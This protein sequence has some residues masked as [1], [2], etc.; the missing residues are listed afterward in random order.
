MTC[1]S[2]QDMY[3]DLSC[4]LSLCD[5]RDSGGS[6]LFSTALGVETVA[7]FPLLFLF[8]EQCFLCAALHVFPQLVR[9]RFLCSSN[10]GLIS[11][12]SPF[13]FLK[14]IYIFSRSIA[15]LIKKI[16]KKREKLNS[17]LKALL[18]NICH[19]KVKKHINNPVEWLLHQLRFLVL[20]PL[21]QTNADLNSANEVLVLIHEMVLAYCSPLFMAISCAKRL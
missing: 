5:N 18:T 12:T 20:E 1:I 17:V 3:S 15:F 9:C 11:R 10:H 19:L 13:R 16:T 4:K 8:L 7:H 6:L 21:R 2:L 14:T